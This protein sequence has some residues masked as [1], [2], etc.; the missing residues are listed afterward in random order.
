MLEPARAPF[1]KNRRVT[2]SKRR[3]QTRG[4]H[5]K[6][7]LRTSIALRELDRRLVGNHIDGHGHPVLAATDEHAANRCHVAVVAPPRHGD[8]VGARQHTVLRSRNERKG[9][10]FGVPLSGYLCR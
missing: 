4:N 5:A 3:L 8:V 2:G 9:Q 6:G 1:R 7:E 10:I